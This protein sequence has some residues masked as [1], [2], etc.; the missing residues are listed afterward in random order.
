MHKVNAYIIPL[1][2]LLLLILPS[3]ASYNLM[4]SEKNDSIDS[5]E[6]VPPSDRYVNVKGPDQ[7]GSPNYNE[8]VSSEYII[9]KTDKLSMSI[10]D[11]PDL[12]VGTVFDSRASTNTTDRYIEVLENGDAIFPKMGPISV[13]GLS[14]SELENKLKAMYSEIIVDP[15]IVIRVENLE[16]TI[17]GAVNNPGNFNLARKSF[18]LAEVIGM[19]GGLDKFAD[20][21][22]LKLIRNNET[23]VLD[24]TRN[25][26]SFLNSLNLYAGD[27]MY[28]P[29]NKS[30]NLSNRSP[31]I[32]AVTS[33]VSTVILLF[34]V[35]GN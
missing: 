27:I 11:H 13:N 35:F 17:I 6:S 24:L 4:Q 26:P 30:K 5:V 29:Y 14:T 10:W 1:L 7:S 34:S 31:G 16:L 32:I 28:V 22:Q 12:S 15:Q 9:K 25:D 21:K 2:A 33:V 8:S 3:C 20:T 18:T 23:F 19:A